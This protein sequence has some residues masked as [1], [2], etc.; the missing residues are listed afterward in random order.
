MAGGRRR[1]AGLWDQGRIAPAAPAT[2][3][4]R[5]VLVAGVTKP[6]NHARGGYRPG[7]PGLLILGAALPLACHNEKPVLVV[8]DAGNQRI[9]PMDVPR[10]R[11]RPG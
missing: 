2:D 3:N 4:P 1:R 9:V 6:V 10:L 7:M 11:P 5:V 8:A